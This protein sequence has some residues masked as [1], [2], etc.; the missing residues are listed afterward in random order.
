MLTEQITIP[1]SQGSTDDWLHCGYVASWKWSNHGWTTCPLSQETSQASIQEPDVSNVTDLDDMMAVRSPAVPLRK[2]QQTHLG[3]PLPVST[4]CSLTW[5]RDSWLT[6]QICFDHPIF[7]GFPSSFLYLLQSTSLLGS[8]PTTLDK[9]GNK[10]ATLLWSS[11]RL[12]W[13][14]EIQK[15]VGF[16]SISQ[17]IFFLQNFP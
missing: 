15:S 10:T 2:H 4:L 16:I 8:H 3:V 11:H 13:F 12:T 1:P 5:G 17:L 9:Y 7:V 6:F 14:S